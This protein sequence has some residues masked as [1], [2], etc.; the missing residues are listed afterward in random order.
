MEK[1]TAFQELLQVE[2]RFLVSLQENLK[3]IVY[4]IV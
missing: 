4:K 2:K 3:V 1:L